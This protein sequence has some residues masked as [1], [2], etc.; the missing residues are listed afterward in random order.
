M[1]LTRADMQCRVGSE[2]QFINGITLKFVELVSH[3]A[4][5]RRPRHCTSHKTIAGDIDDRF[6][7]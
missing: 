7:S 2:Q 3:E 4:I 5:A 6:T 1:G